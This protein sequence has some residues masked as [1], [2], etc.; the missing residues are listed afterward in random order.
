MRIWVYFN[1]G[2][3]SGTLI[4]IESRLLD[5]GK[6]FRIRI[7]KSPT[8]FEST[9]LG[10]STLGPVPIQVK[11]ALKIAI[12]SL[13]P[14]LMLIR[15]HSCMVSRALYVE[16]QDSVLTVPTYYT[17]F[18]F[19]SCLNFIYGHRHS[20]TFSHILTWTVYSY[21]DYFI[22]T[23]IFFFSLLHVHLFRTH[24]YAGRTK[25]TDQSIIQCTGKEA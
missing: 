14:L 3:F 12:C 6:D 16:N 22:Y 21:I 7:H 2:L 8:W 13:S 17:L 25:C 9:K 18:F 11:C 19:F 1:F 5:F 10:F 15:T 24:T 23:H 4:R 20:H